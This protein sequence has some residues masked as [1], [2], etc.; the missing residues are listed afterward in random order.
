[1]GGPI[2]RFQQPVQFRLGRN[3]VFAVRGEVDSVTVLVQ[4]TLTNTRGQVVAAS[5]LTSEHPNPENPG[6]GLLTVHESVSDAVASLSL[7]A[8][9][10]GAIAGARALGGF[11]RA[12]VDLAE[13]QVESHIDAVRNEAT[14]RVKAWTARTRAW[15]MDASALFSHTVG[16]ARGDLTKRQEGVD[17][18]TRLAAEMAPDRTLLR[19]L[20]VVVPH[21]LDVEGLGTEDVD[22]E[23]D[24]TGER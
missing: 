17:A 7:S 2:D 6:F 15:R 10:T 11:V 19:P 18:E 4:A 5:F 21:D 24:G 23:N 12:A 16:A 13:A 1:V 9:N 20:L 22:T 14:D 3:Q 8:T